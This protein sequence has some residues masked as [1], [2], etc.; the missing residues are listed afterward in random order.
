M[1]RQLV[2]A[3]GAPHTAPRRAAQC[4]DRLYMLCSSP[5][6]QEVRWQVVIKANT[7]ITTGLVPPPAPHDLSPFDPDPW[8]KAV[9]SSVLPAACPA[10]TLDPP[11]S[12]IS[13][14]PPC[15]TRGARVRGH[16]GLVLQGVH[17]PL[18][19]GSPSHAPV[20]CPP[21]SDMPFSTDA[22]CLLLHPAQR[23]VPMRQLRV[24]AHAAGPC[25]VPSAPT[26]ISLA[27]GYTYHLYKP[28]ALPYRLLQALGCSG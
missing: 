14:A 15:S 24:Y 19:H 26:E 6:L 9:G 21:P 28:I 20:H 18:L 12:R 25:S 10:T 22:P 8:F 23:S 17:R 13:L 4:G 7:V 2:C 27:L 5:S 1:K 16:H 11:H 3:A